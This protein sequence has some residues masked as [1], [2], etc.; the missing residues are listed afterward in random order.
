[1]LPVPEGWAVN[2][3]TFSWEEDVLFF[4]AVFMDDGGA[5]VGTITRSLDF[6][7]RKVYHAQFK[8]AQEQQ[9]QGIGRMVLR[10]QVDLYAE[11]GFESVGLMAGNVGAYAWARYGFVP[12]E[13]NELEDIIEEM[14]A[15]L[16]EER[17]ELVSEYGEEAVSIMEINLEH[18][19]REPADIRIIAASPL[20]KALLLERGQ[21][22]GVL[23]L[24]DDETMRIFRAYVGGGAR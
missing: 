11:L 23:D 17:D 14:S 21:W 8:V 18:Y 24:T 6:S 15:Y 3:G 19:I 9:G 5:S 16:S 2:I 10:S 20:G 12:E 7:T 1:M 22:A 4:H 13:L